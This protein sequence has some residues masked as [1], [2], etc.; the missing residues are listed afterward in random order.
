MAAKATE[1]QPKEPRWWRLRALLLFDCQPYLNRE[2]AARLPDW[3]DV[4]QK[5]REHD[6]GNALYDYLAAWLHWRE[7]VDTTTATM[8]I[9]NQ[10]KFDFGTKYFLRPRQRQFCA[11]AGGEG[12][13]VARA[14][15]RTIVPHIEYQGIADGRDN[16]FCVFLVR[17]EM[18]RIPTYE[19]ERLEKKG[20]LAGALALRRQCGSMLDQLAQSGGKTSIAIVW[21]YIR[22]GVFASL[23]ALVQKHPALVSAEEAVKIKN[24]AEDAADE[25]KTYSEAN[26]RLLATACAAQPTSSS[27]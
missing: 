24:A 12:A 23:Q 13:V 20:D 7:S 18:W 16:L 15:R 26:R 25:E 5:C 6:P 2:T 11:V 19:A 1:L 10:A 8:P 21:P 14:L 4:L 22:A 27:R 9:V 17:S 3:L